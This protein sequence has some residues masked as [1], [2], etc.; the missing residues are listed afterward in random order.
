MILE[1]AQQILIDAYLQVSVI[2]AMTL[3]AVRTIESTHFG[4]SLYQKLTLCRY[5]QL[6]AATTLG[7]L[8]GCGGAIVVIT[9][10]VQ[11]QW[12]FAAVVAALTATMGDAAFVLLA[13]A[14]GSLLVVASVSASV[15][16]LT[17]M[18]V[19]ATHARDYLRPKLISNGTSLSAA[20]FLPAQSD[21][22]LMVWYLLL[23]PGT[24]YALLNAA[25]IAPGAVGQYLAFV[26]GVY[27]LFLPVIRTAT[28][29]RTSQAWQ[30]AQLTHFVTCW[31]VLA[32]ALYDVP[33]TYFAWQ[34]DIFVLTGPVSNVFL[35][36]L[37]G[38]IPGCGPQILWTSFYVSGKIQFSSQLTSALSTDGDALLPAIALAPRMAVIA[39]VYSL[40][41]SLVTGLGWY[42]LF[43]W[44]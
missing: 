2:V 1:L 37:V 3:L 13:K 21:W 44:S 19:D 15:A 16:L 14:P 12:S 39:T 8:P 17:G 11:G 33:K 4:Q 22:P 42:Y 6:F 35:A 9:R 20:M 18:L 5:R 26:A 41:P 30:I 38:I 7:L 27:T 24:Y 36:G 32:F 40:I 34:S 23:I 10:F 25:Q 29:T 31:V 28:A 43:E